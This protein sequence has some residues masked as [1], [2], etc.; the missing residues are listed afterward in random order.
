MEN[1]VIRR[2]DL[3]ISSLISV[4]MLGGLPAFAQGREEEVREALFALDRRHGGRLGVAILD[5]GSGRVIAHRGQERFAM[6]STF[7]FVAAAFVLA[8]VDRGEES[9]DRR[10]SY[11]KT[12]LVTYSP[13]TEK[14]VDTGLTVAELC[15]A[16]VTLSDNAAGNLLLDSFGGPKGL[17]S[18]MRSLGDDSSRLD[19]RE[20]ELNEATPGDPRDTTTPVAMAQ[21]LRQTVLGAALS[22]ASRH[23]LT[24]WLVANKTG[25]KR[26][27]AGVPKGWRVG[28]RTGTGSN[29]ATNDI[30]V[31][32]PP[33][34]APLIVTAYY[35][36]S[37]G[38][39]PE[40]EAVLAE[41]GRLAT[42]L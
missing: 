6:C 13:V 32:W 9:L 29:N 5:S 38:S 8:R 21:I 14:H 26:L 15:D 33:G 11:T 35:A 31:I 12:D 36:E 37:R 17:T 23:Q 34:R 7:K 25:D 41:V 40:R 27:R 16:A 2:R 20:L 28:D 10:V 39:L 3:L 4:P 30:G 1:T 19:R 24:A 18:Y 42:S 22:P